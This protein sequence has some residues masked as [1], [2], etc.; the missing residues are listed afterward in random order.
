MDEAWFLYLNHLPASIPGLGGLAVVL[1]KYGIGLYP[2]L[3]L[4]LW[5]RG[6]GEAD[7][8]RYG[9]LLAVVAGVLALGIN[10]V[11]NAAVPRPRP[12]LTLPAHVLVARP[13]DPSFPSDHAAFA[14]AIAVM[15]FLHRQWW[16]VLG[17]LGAA[18][19]GAARVMVGVHYPSD[20]WGAI[21]VGSVAAMI[22][23]LAR[24]LLRPLLS[25]TLSVARL[26]RLA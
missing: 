2:A 14:M 10:A 12:F 19:I 6:S 1:A 15:L 18:V 22:V 7:G 26:L 17:L 24:Q 5:W 9:L 16:G 21:L 11:L 4:W 3:L 23:F 25:F 8:R 13:E 20:V